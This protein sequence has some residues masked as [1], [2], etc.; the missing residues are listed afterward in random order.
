[1]LSPHYRHLLSTLCVLL[2]GSVAI[3]ATPLLEL[4][5]RADISS[6]LGP[7]LSPGAQIILKGSPE[8]VNQTIRWTTLGAPTYQAAVEVVT[9]Q[10]VVETMNYAIHNNI[11]FLASSPR[12]GYSLT[13]AS[14]ENGIEIDLKNF[15]QI[16]VDAQANQLTTGGAVIF[17]DVIDALYA[18]GKEMPTGSCSC[19]GLI[20]AT[21]GGGVG[22]LQGL[23]G[24]ILDSLLSV[25]IA[26]ADGCVV[27]ASETENADLFW[28]IRGA[29]HNFGIILSA[30]YKI[31]DQVPQG[32][33]FN[34]DFIFAANKTESMYTMLKGLAANQPPELSALVLFNWD[35]DFNQTVITVNA[36]YAGPEDAGRAAVQ[37]F[38]DQ[39]PLVQNFTVVPWNKL[40][41]TA[42]FGF[43]GPAICEKGNRR[44]QWAAGVI[45][46]DPPTYVSVLKQFEE[47]IT[48]YPAAIDS[49]V[50][51]QLLPNQ[52]AVA[53][54]DDTTAYPYRDFIA[55]ALLEF[56]YTTSAL[57][58]AIT[59]YAQ[60]MRA[61]MAA[62]AGTGGLEVYS[63][64]SHGDETP[65]QLYSARKLP[66][67]EALKKQYD[68]LGVFSHYH[69]IPLS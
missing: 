2:C 7:K 61:T 48:E 45:N 67:L 22:R 4:D 44:S 5:P 35:K 62:T 27:T 64:Y 57:D 56:K 66:R 68:P 25:R 40:I 20:G 32:K 46:I 47:M 23:H 42:G 69:P 19:V 11:S 10:D 58:D 37:P 63:S 52:A 9:E 41:Q 36:V 50:D 17:E 15:N 26:L 18:A 59:G 60:R 49:S 8:F 54:P 13:L 34:A 53:V 33:H 65:Q 38:V 24:L 30:T 16:H 31:Y 12:H 39:G 6:T 43:T 3:Q 51:F 1:M 28:G 55:H 14:I 29:G 21:L